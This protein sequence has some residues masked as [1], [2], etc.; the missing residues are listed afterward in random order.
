[1]HTGLLVVECGES[2]VQG[3]VALRWDGCCEASSRAV[4]DPMCSRRDT[5]SVILNLPDY[6]VLDAIDLPSGGRGVIVR[7][8]TI[9]EG[10]PRL[11]G[12]IGPGARMVP[13]TREGPPARGRC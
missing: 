1:M 2:L 10:C 5:A 7:A 12:R 9:A 4:N 3:P 13:S 8:D 11:R 6:Q